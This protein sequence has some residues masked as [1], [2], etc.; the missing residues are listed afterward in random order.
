MKT[1][2]GFK[3]V[4][5]SGIVAGI[6]FLMAEMLML[7]MTGQSPFGPPRMMAAMVMGK[8][9]LP[10]PATFDMGIMMVAMI[11]HL[12]ISLIAAF[13]FGTIYK[14]FSRSFMIALL[15]GVVY[16]LLFYFAAFYVMTGIWPWFEMA[17]GTISII[18]HILFGLALGATFHKLSGVTA[19]A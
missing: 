1:S 2:V 12:M 13:V 18:G 19:E 10:P 9:V 14:L 7:A 3:S 4:V 16:G 15:L 5:I 11:V 17:R 6:V 8:E